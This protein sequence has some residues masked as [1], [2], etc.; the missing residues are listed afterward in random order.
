MNNKLLEIKDLRVHFHLDEGTVKAVNGVSYDIYEGKTL[1]VVGE[2]GCGKSVTAQAIMRI[3]PPP[4]QISENS[5]ILLHRPAGNGKSETIDLA[6]FDN[7]GPEIRAIRGR[8][9][10]MI[11]IVVSYPLS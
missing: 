7:D 1:G 10:A 5:Q 4:G 6:Q 11:F 8:D 9:I 3:V 2:S